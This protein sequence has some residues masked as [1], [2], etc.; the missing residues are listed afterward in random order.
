MSY[1]HS[2]TLDSPM[3]FAGGQWTTD[4]A[5]DQPGPGCG[6]PVFVKVTGQYPLP[7]P[8]QNPITVL[9]G[10]VHAEVSGSPACATTMDFDET[11]TRTGD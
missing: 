1:L 7:Q 5:H 9:A 11:F 6:G 4:E 10:H 2:K 3:V 8:P